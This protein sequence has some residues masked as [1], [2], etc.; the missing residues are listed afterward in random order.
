VDTVAP[1]GPGDAPVILL[2]LIDAGSDGFWRLL[3]LAQQLLSAQER[4]EFGR[5]R[6][7]AV[8][9]RRIVC[10]AWL[11]VLLGEALDRAPA[12]VELRRERY[13]R[14]ELVDG[15]RGVFNVSQ[16]D[17]M[18]AV[19]LL[20]RPWQAARS[21]RIGIDVETPARRWTPELARALYSPPEFEWLQARAA[22][23]R[24]AAFLRLWTLREAVLKAD[25][26]GL[27]LDMRQ[28]RF[29]PDSGGDGPPGCAGAGSVQVEETALIDPRRWCCWTRQEGR[30]VCAIAVHGDHCD[31]AFDIEI[32]CLDIEEAGERMAAHLPLHCQ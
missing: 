32:E 22:E 9:G 29:C 2:S 10:R 28:L 15:P 13:G 18:A 11:R 23:H 27:S 8:R 26:R 5:V 7:A 21:P 16:S 4:I 31:A 24:D 19:A 20:Q 3:P 1:G 12:E 17:G 30:A 6:S 25:G 14:L